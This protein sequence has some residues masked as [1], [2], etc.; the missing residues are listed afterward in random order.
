CHPNAKVVARYPFEV[1]GWQGV[2]QG[3]QIREFR[4]DGIVMAENFVPPAIMAAQIHG[5]GDA[6]WDDMRGYNH[7][8]ASGVLVEDTR[9]GQVTRAF[10]R[11]TARYDITALDHERFLRG[12]RY[13]AEMHFAMG[14][15][16]VYLPFPNLAAITSPDE[17]ALIEKTQRSPSTLEL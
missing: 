5:H 12:I 6:A 9:P 13:L 7:M 3:G 14:A 11:P 15:E 4:Q 2:S 8:V 16:K 10:G 17:L 1:K